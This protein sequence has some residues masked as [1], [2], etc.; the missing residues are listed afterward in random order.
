MGGGPARTEVR[1]SEKSGA[2]D[3]ALGAGGV[4]RE[5][6]EGV[7]AMGPEAAAAAG[8]GADG[9]EARY[10]HKPRRGEHKRVDEEAGEERAVGKRAAACSMGWK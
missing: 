8:L 4:G 6:G 3:A 7:G 2:C 10:C 5:A 9:G 1:G